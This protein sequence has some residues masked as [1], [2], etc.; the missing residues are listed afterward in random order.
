MITKKRGFMHLNNINIVRPIALGFYLGATIG[1]AYGALLALTDPKQIC[2]SQLNEIGN[3]TLRS[4]E[5]DNGFLTGC[6]NS[7]PGPFGFFAVYTIFGAGS[8]A[9]MAN[10]YGVAIE[11]LRLNGIEVVGW[12]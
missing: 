2:T 4:P 5:Y 6:I 11:A 8:G 10:I 7:L 9:F 12:M 1:G 3:Q